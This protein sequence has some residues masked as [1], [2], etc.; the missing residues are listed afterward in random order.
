MNAPRIRE[1]RA[2]KCSEA[3][4]IPRIREQRVLRRCG[5]AA[6]SSECTQDSRAEGLEVVRSSECTQD[7]RAEGCEAVP[8]GCPQQ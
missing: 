8:A 6:R 4:N 7:W 5:Q 1:Q 3:V 2:L